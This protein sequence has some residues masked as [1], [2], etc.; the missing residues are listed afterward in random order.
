[1]YSILS[2]DEHWETLNGKHWKWLKLL[3]NIVPIIMLY[4]YIEGIIYEEFIIYIVFII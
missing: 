4:V 3:L 1:M 2:T